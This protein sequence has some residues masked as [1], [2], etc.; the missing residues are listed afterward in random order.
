MVWTKAIGLQITDDLRNKESAK[1]R[2]GEAHFIA[3]AVGE[4]PAKDIKARNLDDVM[5]TC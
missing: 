2:C 4:N 5:A 3:L 1:I